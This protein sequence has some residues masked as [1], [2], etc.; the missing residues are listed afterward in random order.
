MKCGEQ[1]EQLRI[2]DLEYHYKKFGD[3]LSPVKKAYFSCNKA[4]ISMALIFGSS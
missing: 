2:K 4:A 1:K 3:V